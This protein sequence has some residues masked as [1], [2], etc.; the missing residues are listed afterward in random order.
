MA[1]RKG[2]CAFYDMSSPSN[3]S[4]TLGVLKNRTSNLLEIIHSEPGDLKSTMSCGMKTYYVTFVDD[5]SKF[6]KVYLLSGKAEA[7]DKFL[8]HKAE[9]EN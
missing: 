1:S 3:P 2:R 4:S 6:T 9:V 7:I 8:I 5:C